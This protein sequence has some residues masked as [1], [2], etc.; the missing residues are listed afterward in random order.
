MILL[1]TFKLACELYN[2]N[3]Q[4]QIILSVLDVGDEWVFNVIDK[5]TRESLDIPPVA[6]SKKDGTMR[7]FFPPANTEKLKKAIEIELSK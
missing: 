3:Y 1:I 4:N 2:N 6:I 7:N 5:K